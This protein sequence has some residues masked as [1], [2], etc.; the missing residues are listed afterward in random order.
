[1]ATSETYHL[2]YRNITPFSAGTPTFHDPWG[3]D[4]QSVTYHFLFGD[5]CKGMCLSQPPDRLTISI[6][7]AIQ[8]ILLLVDFLLDPLHAVHRVSVPSD[9]CGQRLVADLYEGFVDLLTEAV[10]AADVE[11]LLVGVIRRGTMVAVRGCI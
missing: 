5:L 4:H 11:Q 3:N 7:K 9:F 8:L 10:V 6:G 2:S 1:M